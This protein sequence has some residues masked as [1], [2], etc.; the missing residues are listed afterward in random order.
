MF[1][2]DPKWVKMEKMVVVAGISHS[3]HF[4]STNSVL[5]HQKIFLRS[6]LSRVNMWEPD[7]VSARAS[8]LNITKSSR[9]QLCGCRKSLSTDK[10]NTLQALDNY[11]FDLGPYRM[12]HILA[13][14]C[15]MI[16]PEDIS[17]ALTFAAIWE[18]NLSLQRALGIRTCFQFV[19]NYSLHISMDTKNVRCKH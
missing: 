19:Q 1:I 9:C 4:H 6:A 10:S 8:F 16:E 15:D 11:P 13:M 18:W 14:S 3:T 17:C 5:R 12:N 2:F 7:K